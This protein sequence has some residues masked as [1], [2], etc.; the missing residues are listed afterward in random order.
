MKAGKSPAKFTFK[1]LWKSPPPKKVKA[2]Q[3]LN[4]TAD[5]RASDLTSKAGKTS[6]N[7]TK[8]STACRKKAQN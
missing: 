8:K 5:T 1:D 2:V 3:K 4:Q 6:N 7:D